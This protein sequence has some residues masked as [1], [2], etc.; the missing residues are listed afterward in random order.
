MKT[1]PFRLFSALLLAALGLGALGGCTSAQLGRVQPWE[2]AALA[3]YT[4]RSDR[5]PL[6]TVMSEHIFFSREASA[7]G[8]GIGGSGC[9]C[10]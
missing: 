4:M 8:R 2:R 1:N 10:N 5:D 9:G 6:A 7:G 3:D